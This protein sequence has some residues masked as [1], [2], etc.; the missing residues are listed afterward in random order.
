MI[1]HSFR[2]IRT[3]QYLDAL[4]VDRGRAQWKDAMRWAIETML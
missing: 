1:T 3:R 4:N 2:L